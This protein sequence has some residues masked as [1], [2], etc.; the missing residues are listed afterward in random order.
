L[1]DVS[2]IKSL[3]IHAETVAAVEAA[4]KHLGVAAILAGAFVRD[5]HLRRHGLEP[6]RRTNDVDV[7]V[8]VADW[9]VFEALKSR[10]VADGVF[11]R[12]LERPHRLVH[13][14]GLPIDLVPF[15]GV[16]NEHRRI[17][18]PPE[19][20]FEMDAFGFKEAAAAAVDVL[21]PRR[22]RARIVSV[23]GLAL[24]K[25]VAWEERR[26]VAPR[27]DAEDLASIARDY[28][29]LGNRER[30]FT[31]FSAWTEEPDFDVE[32]AGARLL[33]V[34]VGS[35]LDASGRTRVAAVLRRQADDDRP[36]ELPGELFPR[37]PDRGRALV[38]ALLR[39]VL[40]R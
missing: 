40:G 5:L 39:G 4:R 12:D 2:K 32:R 30:L 18:W 22:V 14:N 20:D 34:D 36:G 6:A 31:D 13:R 7:A 25:I 27:K 11:T 23:P 15:D 8:A 1:L 38:A 19:G 17:A 33:G 10:L 21:L 24:L 26:R 28:L 37:D 16:E 3:A 29:A 35:L 9:S